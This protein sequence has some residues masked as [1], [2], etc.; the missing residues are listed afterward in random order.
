MQCLRNKTFFFGG[1]QPIFYVD[2]L[3]ELK[4]PLINLNVL[5]LYIGKNQTLHF[6]K[7]SQ[8]IC[9]ERGEKERKERTSIEEI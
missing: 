9:E 1:G 5:H 3:F 2:V 8:Q 4:Y 6:E 7:R